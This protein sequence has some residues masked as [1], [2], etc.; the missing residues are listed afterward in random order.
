MT[1]IKMVIEKC[2]EFMNVQLHFGSFTLTPMGILLG[3]FVLY[4]AVVFVIKLFD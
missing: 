4:I 3:M 2:I 1:N